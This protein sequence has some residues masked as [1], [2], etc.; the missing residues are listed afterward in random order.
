MEAR[1]CTF[2]VRGAAKGGPRDGPACGG[3][4]RSQVWGV[5]ATA[6]LGV[7]LGRS[8][9]GSG[10]WPCRSG[11]AAGALGGGQLVIRLGSLH[12]PL[13]TSKSLSWH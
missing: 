6:S 10:R 9:R 7:G 8:P 12:S 2:C 4:A 5:E 13:L 3:W 11:N 1:L